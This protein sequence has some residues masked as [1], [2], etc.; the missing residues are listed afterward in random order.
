MENMF[1]CTGQDSA[2]FYFERSAGVRAGE[3]ADS[4]GSQ[5]GKRSGSHSFYLLQDIPWAHGIARNMSTVQAERS[6]HS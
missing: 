1:K 6:F 4:A 5:A 2:A 3:Q